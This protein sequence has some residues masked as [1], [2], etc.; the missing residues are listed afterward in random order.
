MLLRTRNID[1]N[2]I[3]NHENDEIN[4]IN[5][6]ENNEKE[7]KISYIILEK[8]YDV[9]IFIIQISIKTVKYIISF[10]GIY[11]LW[12]VLHYFASHLYIKFCVPQ[13]IFGFFISPFLTATPQCQGLRWVV[14]NGA[15]FISNMWVV[16]GTWLCSKTLF[17]TQ[18]YNDDNSS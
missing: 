6:N 11:L 1:E 17:I 8:S 16:F 4:I 9:F 7:Y 12:I 10:S 3:S 5:K 14:Y 13:T 15:N 18:K 2:I